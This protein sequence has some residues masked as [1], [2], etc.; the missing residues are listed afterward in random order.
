MTAQP[1]PLADLGHRDCRWPVND[2]TPPALHL[3]C[4][5]RAAEGKPY[6]TSHLR[7]A[8]RVKGQDDE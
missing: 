7:L 6:C 1:R 5:E 2:A 8:Y 4:G 3:F